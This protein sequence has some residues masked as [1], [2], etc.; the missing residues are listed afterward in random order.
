MARK[1]IIAVMCGLM[2]ASRANANARVQIPD[3]LI[4]WTILAIN[5]VRS[6]KKEN[7]RRVVTMTDGHVYQITGI[8]L[9][10]LPLSDAVIF[11]KR[12][13]GREPAPVPGE[14]EPASVVLRR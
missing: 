1:F 3:S 6:D 14:K 12:A 11:G 13:F 8:G 7:Y 5:E 4:G 2:L 9:P 10:I